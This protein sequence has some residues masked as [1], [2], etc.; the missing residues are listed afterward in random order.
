MSC[1][2]LPR[3]LAPEQIRGEEVDARADLF[4]LGSIAFEL[5]TGQRAFAGENTVDTLHAI[6]HTPPADL[7]QHRDDVPGSLATIVLRLL[8]KAPA[9]R[10]QSAIDVAWA[11]EQSASPV[12][13][14]APAERNRSLGGRMSASRWLST[15]RDPGTRG[16]CRRHVANEW[17]FAGRFTI[18]DR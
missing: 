14:V 15:R 8:E 11:L 2:A 10:F 9:D 13:A 17:A 6:L 4:A 5:L 12:L 1:L 16:D 18:S 3:Y 7:L